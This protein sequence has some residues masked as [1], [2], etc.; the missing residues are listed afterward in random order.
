MLHNYRATCSG[1]QNLFPMDILEDNFNFTLSDD[2][3]GPLLSTVFALEM[4]TGLLANLFVISI[5]FFH[6]KSWKQSSTIFLTNLLL[7]DFVL[8][9]AVMPFS[10]ISTASGKWIFGQ[11]IRQKYDVCQFIAFMMWYGALLITMTLAV[12][13][14]D[15]FLFIVKP[16]IHKR[17]MKPHT[18][19]IIVATVWISCAL[20]NSTPLYGIG[21]F[22]F[23]KSHGTCSPEWDGELA[24]VIFSILIF[25][26][27]LCV[28]MV[29]SIW[30]CCFTRKFLQQNQRG[31]GDDSNY[32]FKKRQFIHLGVFGSLLL[33]Y[34]FCF[35]PGFIVAVISTA[36][37]LPDA[38][39]AFILVCF[40]VIT[41][42]NPLVQSCFRPDVKNVMGRIRTL[43]CLKCCQQHKN[44]QHTN[45]T[46][47][48]NSSQH[49]NTKYTAN[50]QHTTSIV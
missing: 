35:G 42:A 14:F 28:I 15:R 45:A 31:T 4:V 6:P 2:I 32:Q 47:A 23:A 37:I 41:V 29:T 26:V 21:K 46:Y 36:V 30:T 13:S 10:I 24:Y 20:L 17:Y 38:V 16:F 39:H 5:N 11:T 48:A 34:T 19:V 8:V 9:I 12:I 40:L 43:C 50:S 7:A 33:V 3:N 25:T 18:A 22:T 44:S 27:M 1:I 49:T